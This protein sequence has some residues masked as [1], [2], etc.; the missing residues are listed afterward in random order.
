MCWYISLF[1]AIRW[2]WFS[3]QWASLFSTFSSLPNPRQ[4][5]SGFLSRVLPAWRANPR[6]KQKMERVRL[7]RR[8][9][10]QTVVIQRSTHISVTTVGCTWTKTVWNLLLQSCQWNTN[11]YFRRF[12][13]SFQHEGFLF[14]R[15][16]TEIPAGIWAIL[17]FIVTISALG[18]TQPFIQWV[19]GALY[20]VVKRP[21]HE[22]DRS[23]PPSNQVK[24]AWSY[25]STPPIRLHGVAL[26]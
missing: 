4:H 6:Q 3:L 9:G 15:Y 19:P 22:A 14:R 2:Q 20:P 5:S 16:P 24:N 26:K 23:P 18:P 13:I 21:V 17:R 12:T 8:A 25:T 10:W 11:A 7:W 1:R